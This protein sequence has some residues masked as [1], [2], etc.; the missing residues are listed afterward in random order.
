MAWWTAVFLGL[1]QGLAEFLPVSSSGHL[2]LF[3]HL[4][5][6]DDGGLL[7]DIILHIATLL[8]VV[9]VYHKKIWGLIRRPFCEYNVLLFIATAITCVFVLAFKNLIDKA[10]NIQFLPFAFIITA[11]VLLLPAIVKPKVT[12]GG[13]RTQTGA[14]VRT[15]AGRKKSW[16]TAAGEKKSW[17]AAAA[18]GFAQGLAVIPAFSRSGWTITAGQLSGMDRTAAADFS[19]LMSVPIILA[20][21]FYEIMAG[22]EIVSVGTGSIIIAFVSAFVSGIVAIKFMLNIIKKIDL[23]W[24]SAYLFILG[25]VLIFFL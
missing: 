23:R 5:H 9:V 21:L 3:Q 16:R 4:L 10:F 25:A 2:I 19:F 24:F 14:A 6:I 12:G 17:R 13:G 18:M 1:V 22:G 20:S 7:F 15:A 8:A 11:A